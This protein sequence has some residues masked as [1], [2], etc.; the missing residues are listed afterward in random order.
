MDKLWSLFGCWLLVLLHLNPLPTEAQSSKS[1]FSQRLSVFSNNLYNQLSLLKPDQNIVFS[2]FSIQ[3]CAAMARLGAKKETAEDL[4]RG[5]G[6]VS[7]TKK[8]AESFHQA[9]LPYKKSKILH[10]ANRIFVMK[11]LKLRHEFNKLLSK[12]FLSSAKSLDFGNSKKAAADINKWVEKQT[13]NFIK[14][15]VDPN[16]ISSKS[17]IVLVNAIH[18]KGNWVH[19]F[20]VR[21]TKPEPFKLKDGKSIQVPMMNVVN[22]F[23]HAVLPELDATV[24][25]LPY[26]DSDLSMLIVLPNSKTG[27]PQLEKKL[28]STQLSE[29][30]KKLVKLNQTRVMVKLPKFKAEFKMELTDVFQKLGMTRMFSSSADFSGMLK[31]SQGVQISSIMHQAFIDVNE[32]G[33]EAAAAT[34]ITDNIKSLLISP[35]P[36]HF[37]ADH[38]FAYYLLNKD[39]YV[40]F[41][42]KLLKP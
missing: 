8:I 1:D 29:I 2:P 7:D 13:K 6:L 22:T 36:V 23:G 3:T 16:S 5:L 37:H 25:Q 41:A 19:Q 24:L 15:V 12:Q 18:F 17:R 40:L 33:T 14:N 10:I 27:L 30:T 9:L 21:E 28:R 11:G 34:A 4:D 35:D 38:P 20:K 39:N 32:L 42:G 26:K 31:N